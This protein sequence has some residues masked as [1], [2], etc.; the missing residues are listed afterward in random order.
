MTLPPMRNDVTAKAQ[1]FLH[2]SDGDIERR[3][4]DQN[5]TAILFSHSK[6]TFLALIAEHCVLKSA[7]DKFDWS[8][9]IQTLQKRDVPNS[10]AAPLHQV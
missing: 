3:L 4:R 8:Q 1:S 7:T 5:G 6:A 2:A 10:V 9:V